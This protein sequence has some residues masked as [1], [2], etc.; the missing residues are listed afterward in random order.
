VAGAT[1]GGKKEEEKQRYR[2]AKQRTAILYNLF[3]HFIRHT[4]TSPSCIPHT[5][6]FSL[7]PS[8]CVCMCVAFA[9]VQ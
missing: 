9:E 7:T 2:E 1:T 8:V 4:H 5:L 6:V 3:Y